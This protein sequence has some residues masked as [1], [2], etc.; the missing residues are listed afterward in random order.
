M[1]R[2]KLMVI[3][4]LI[5]L[6]TAGIAANT[7]P[8]DKP[9]YKNLKVLPKKIN[10]DDLDK[11]M[12]E[13]TSSLGVKC[14]FCHAPVKDNPRKMDFASDEKPEKDIARNMFKM[15]A[16]INK[17]FFHYSKSEQNPVPPISCITCHHGNP[18][19]EGNK[20]DSTHH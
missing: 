10:H 18:H 1:F 20:S 8:A 19:P 7:P 14:N 17:K 13:W 9:T 6:V 11:V 2:K 15:T 16:R 5:V 4:V 12:H 3:L